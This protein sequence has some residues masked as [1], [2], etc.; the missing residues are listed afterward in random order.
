METT[1]KQQLDALLNVQNIDTKLYHIFQLR[2]DLPIEIENLKED[3]GTLNEKLNEKIT[4]LEE[5]K[6][7]VNHQK[8]DIKEKQTSLGKYEKQKD[9]ISNS[10]EYDAVTKAIELHSLDIQLAEKKIKNSYTIIEN[11]QPEID[12]LKESI[13]EV[14]EK[15]K[16]KEAKL[17]STIADQSKI[18]KE[19]LGQRHKFLPLIDSEV[20]SNYDRVRT[21]VSNGLGAVKVTRGACGAC[22]MVVT[23]QKQIDVASQFA[24][25]RCD[26]CGATLLDASLE[27]IPE[28]GA[29]AKIIEEHQEATI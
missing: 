25:Q 6:N 8:S 26:H 13:E 10:R 7:T 12:K 1:I 20:L 29:Y 18:E 17:E 21:R 2:G 24:I 3:Y 19:L 5:A 22:F 23:T 27:E 15:I 11:L 4:R 28:N 16:I 9:E 14:T